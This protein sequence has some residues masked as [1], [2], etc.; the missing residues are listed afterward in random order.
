M[1]LRS[2]FQSFIEIFFIREGEYLIMEKIRSQGITRNKMEKLW[3]LVYNQLQRP[4]FSMVDQTDR[5]F[6]NDAWEFILFPEVKIFNNKICIE[7]NIGTDPTKYEKNEKIEFEIDN[8]G[9]ICNVNYELLTSNRA[10]DL[11]NILKGSIIEKPDFF[12]LI[13]D[14]DLKIIENIRKTIIFPKCV[15]VNNKLIIHQYKSFLPDIKFFLTRD[16]QNKKIVYA[17]IRSRLDSNYSQPIKEIL[18]KTNLK[19]NVLNY[20]DLDSQS[21]NKLV[22]LFSIIPLSEINYS[23][24]KNEL[25]IT[26]DSNKLIKIELGYSIETNSD[27]IPYKK[28]KF[29]LLHFFRISE[30]MGLNLYRH[31]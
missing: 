5:M 29:S 25:I 22:W 4:D 11:F 28:I 26:V 3:N 6:I 7:E 23:E 15:L 1:V 24:S 8:S 16:K 13:N 10:K 2:Y 31:L 12:T 9:R 27:H 30:E 19:S 21:Q 20:E 14:Q 17:K 18:D